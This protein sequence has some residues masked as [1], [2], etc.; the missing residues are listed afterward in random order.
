LNIIFYDGCHGVPPCPA[1]Y[2]A[3]LPGGLISSSV[4]EVSLLGDSGCKISAAGKIFS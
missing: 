1:L 2:A 4:N 3:R